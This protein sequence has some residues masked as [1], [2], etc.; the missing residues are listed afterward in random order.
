M[1]MLALT[2]MC[3]STYET[4]NFHRMALYTLRSFFKV[5]VLIQNLFC[6]GH[7]IFLWVFQTKQGLF[8]YRLLEQV[9]F[10]VILSHTLFLLL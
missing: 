8:V 7:L 1:Y 9:L 2:G 5:V 10:Y 3:F 6:S 4:A